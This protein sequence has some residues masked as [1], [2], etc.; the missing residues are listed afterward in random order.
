MNNPQMK[1]DD[2]NIKYNWWSF[3]IHYFIYVCMLLRLTSLNDVG[4]GWKRMLS[5]YK[6]GANNTKWFRKKNRMIFYIPAIDAKRI[7]STEKRHSCKCV[8]YVCSVYK[9][10]FL[11]KNNPGYFTSYWAW[12]VRVWS[13]QQQVCS[14]FR[15]H[16]L[17]GF[18][19]NRCAS[20]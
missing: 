7:I 2:T 12:I 10:K 11:K 8:Q 16:R 14:L 19:Q 3:Y 5:I 15:V 1:L 9:S 4:F 20:L 6:M 17:K 13:T 18:R